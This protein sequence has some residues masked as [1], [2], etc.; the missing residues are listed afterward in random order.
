MANKKERK[1]TEKEKLRTEKIDTLTKELESQGYVRKD[2][3]ISMTYASGMG[4]VYFLVAC[5][6]FGA[7][8]VLKNG[9]AFQWNMP[10]LVFL[11]IELVLIFVHEAIHGVTWAIFAPS[12]FK[13]I[14]FGFMLDKLAPYC[15][16]GE[17][18][19]KHAYLL[20]SVMPT[21]ILG[22]IP[23]I[24]AIFINSFPLLLIGLFNILGGGGDLTIDFKI[25]TYKTDASEQVI[26]DHPNECG[27]IF[28]EK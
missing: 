1:L 25:L 13:V 24:A 7:L 26:M 23:C 12:H 3:I 20:G 21:L 6:L 22:V 27:L 9:L 16:C 8:F 18:L 28:F 5:V 11:I 2:Q 17:Q 4:V 15:Y 19:K 14:E 10:F